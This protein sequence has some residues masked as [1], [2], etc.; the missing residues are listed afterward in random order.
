[1][2]PADNGDCQQ[3]W[4]LCQNSHMSDLS[5]EQDGQFVDDRESVGEVLS[6]MIGMARRD[7][8]IYEPYLMP[9]VWGQRPVLDALKRFMIRSAR[10]RG[11]IL[12][13]DPDSA[14]KQSHPL[15]PLYQ[16]FSGRLQLRRCN[17]RMVPPAWSVTVVD[18]CQW[19]YRPAHDRLTGHYHQHPSQR[20]VQ[21]AADV[22]EWWEEASPVE[23]IRVLGI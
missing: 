23:H 6:E 2:Q 7:L 14:I 19:F 21:I 5:T 15:I 11:R 22:D 4:I 18:Q 16:S 10:V 13:V 1:M 12:C 3:T 8:L 17:E 9:A 20:S